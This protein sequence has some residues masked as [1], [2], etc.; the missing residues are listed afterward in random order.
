MVQEIPQVGKLGIPVGVKDLYRPPD[1]DQN[2]LY[3][4]LPLI[5]D[6]EM[7][8]K[9]AGDSAAFDQV[10]AGYDA[11]FTDT[12]LGHMLRDRVWLHLGQR[13]RRGLYRH[14]ES[15]SCPASNDC[16]AGGQ[17]CVLREAGLPRH[18][19]SARHACHGRTI[20]GCHTDGQPGAL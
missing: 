6:I 18:R 17:K 7:E 16:D 5:R 12:T 2:P 1:G 8:E 13:F 15:S 14:A 4:V 19:R 9:I 20:Q 11:S 10:A 3:Y